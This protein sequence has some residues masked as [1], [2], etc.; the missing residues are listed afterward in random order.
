MIGHIVLAT[1]FSTRSDRALRRATI[2]A[3]RSGAT[4]T[5]VHVV[6]DDQ[7]AHLVR[8][9]VETA[10][11]A[12]DETARTIETYDKIPAYGMIVTGDVYAGIIE[13]ADELGADLIV[14]GSHRR[15]FRDLFVGTTAQRTIAHS[16]RP[17]LMAAGIPSAPYERALVALD[18]DEGSDAMA[19]HVGELGALGAAEIVAVHAYDAPARGMLAR[20]MSGDGAIDDYVRDEGRRASEH[21]AR[22][23]GAAGLASARHRPVP[24]KGTPARTIVESAREEEASLIVVGT[25]RRKGIERMFLGSVAEDVIGTADRDVLVVPA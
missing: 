9:Q 24:L 18:L 23:L 25:R 7:P 4:L 6:D 5:M 22:F 17:V 10:R 16:S 14:V 8:A 15:Q 12:L 20:A 1:D 2:L 3:K 11:S 21:L 13:A 19:K